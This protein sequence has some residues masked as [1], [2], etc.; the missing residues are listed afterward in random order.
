MTLV[1]KFALLVLVLN[2]LP[3]YLCART[4]EPAEQ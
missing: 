2:V 3:A 1:E 4:D